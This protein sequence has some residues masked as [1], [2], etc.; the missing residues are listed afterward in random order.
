[1]PDTKRN[2]GDSRHAQAQRH[3]VTCMQMTYA[4]AKHNVRA[5]AR[6]TRQCVHHAL[7]VKVGYVMTERK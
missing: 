4:L 5:P 3:R 7:R 6:R 2:Y 1:M